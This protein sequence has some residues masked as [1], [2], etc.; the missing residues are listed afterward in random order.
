MRQ[1]ILM[2]HA[3]AERQAES[4][5]DR[6]RPLTDRGRADARLMA[7]E[8]AQRGL[9]PDVVLVSSSTR[10]RETWD[11]M[12]EAFGDVDLRIEARLYNA[13]PE[14]IRAFVEELE[15]SAGVLLVLAHNP[16]VQLLAGDLLVESA[17]SPAI[18]ERL[19]GGF[20]TGAAA[21]FQM[22]AAGRATYDGFFTPKAFGGGAEG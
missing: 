19:E 5:Q 1:L 20:P 4:G 18:L 22:D 2:R 16:G 11:E 14:T 8:L 9:R 10:T 6:D 17:A 15:E 12:A 7:R 13:E 3:K 21:V